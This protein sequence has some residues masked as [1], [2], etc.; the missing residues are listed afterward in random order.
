M[1]GRPLP[2]IHRDLTGRDL[3]YFA[4]FSL[5]FRSTSATTR[6]Q[7]TNQPEGNKICFI[8]PYFSTGLLPLVL[9][10]PPGTEAGTPPS[11]PPPLPR[12]SRLPKAERRQRQC[13]LP[14]RAE[15][16][17]AAAAGGERGLEGGRGVARPQRPVASGYGNNDERVPV[18]SVHAVAGSIQAA[19]LRKGEERLRW[20]FIP[21]V[22]FGWA[23]YRGFKSRAEF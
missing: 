9:S 8:S 17:G 5:L 23:K 10:S 16:P 12:P 1:A 15:L 19:R 13:G 14:R 18:V 2:F 6:K 4:S 20:G 11:A 3:F 22:A 21:S 7:T